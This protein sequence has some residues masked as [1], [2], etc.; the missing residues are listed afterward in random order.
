MISRS[1]RVGE[2]GSGQKGYV[3]LVLR[4]EL[5]PARENAAFES[6]SKASMKVGAHQVRLLHDGA[7][8]FGAMFDAIRVAKTEILLEMYWFASDTIGWRIAR[9]LMERASEGLE[10]RVLYDAIGSLEASE[11]MFDA[12]RAGG[13]HVLQF[14]PIAPWR[15]R[16]RAERLTRRN[17]RKMLIIDGEI[18]LTGGV[19]IGDPWLPESEGGNGWRDDMIRVA[20]P[21]AMVMREIFLHAWRSEE[22]GSLREGRLK[23][24]NDDDESVRVLANH[25]Y[26]TQRAIRRAYMKRI[27]AAK[28]SVLIT[29]SYFVPDRTIR[30]A[31]A[32]AAS[33]GVEVRVLVPG[34]S[35]VKAVYYA[36]RSQYG[37]LTKRGVHVHEWLPQVLHSKTAVVDGEW[38]TVGTYNLDYLSWR[39]N[40]EVTLAVED[41]QV[42]GALEKRFRADLEQ[43]MEIDLEHFG[44][45]PLSE[46]VLERVFFWFR[47]FL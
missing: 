47:K 8:C 1:T 4:P 22:S 7:E 36:S 11:T 17:H 26:G 24:R 40:L 14:N 2:P 5:T 21:A 20:G 23:L 37:W 16:F 15:Q 3:H 18:G 34:I 41:A 33:R 42:A 43:S 38:C 27:Y 19:N 6:T 25:Y 44:A 30:M 9:A 45:R 10:V 39:S 29:N 28:R 13:V 32:K 46:R 35:D 12:M 31:L